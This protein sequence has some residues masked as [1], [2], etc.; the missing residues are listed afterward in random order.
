MDLTAFSTISGALGVLAPLCT[1]AL[2]LWVILRTRSRHSLLYRLWQLV[3]GNQEISDPEV[4]AFISEQNSLM[5]FRFIAGVPVSTLEHA[6]Q[7]IQWT[8][9]HNVEMFALRMA[10]EYFDPDLRQIRVQKLP[11]KLMQ[12][13]KLFLATLIGQLGSGGLQGAGGKIVLRR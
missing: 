13:A 1:V 10:G 4:K 12:G 2:F 5:S 3:H 8:K 11:S 6:H 7:L 9:R